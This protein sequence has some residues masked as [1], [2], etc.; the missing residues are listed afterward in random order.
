MKLSRFVK[1]ALILASLACIAPVA[2]ANAYGVWKGAAFNP[3]TH[4][5]TVVAG[6][7]PAPPAT[8]H[9]KIGVEDYNSSWSYEG[10]GGTLLGPHW[11]LFNGWYELKNMWVNL[12]SGLVSPNGYSGYSAAF[13]DEIGSRD[14]SNFTPTSVYAWIEGPWGQSWRGYINIATQRCSSVPDPATDQQVIATFSTNIY[15]GWG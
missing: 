14:P 10:T 13:G 4:R 7:Y 1:L 9:W 2:S 12:S 5:L 15:G 11:S 8:E 6:L 3:C